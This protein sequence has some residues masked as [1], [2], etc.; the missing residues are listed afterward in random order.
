MAKWIEN[1]ADP[2]KLVMQIPAYGIRYKLKDENDH[3]L[4]SAIENFG[5]ASLEEVIIY[6]ASKSRHHKISTLSIK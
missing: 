4:H 3:D 1:G 2:A 6:T 5:R